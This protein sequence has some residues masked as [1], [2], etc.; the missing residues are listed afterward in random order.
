M[1]IQDL[2]GTFDPLTSSVATF[3]GKVKQL[4]H[5]INKLKEEHDK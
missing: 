1:E 2:I 3:S 5:E 4:T